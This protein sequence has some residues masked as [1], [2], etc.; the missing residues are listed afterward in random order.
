MSNNSTLVELNTH[1]FA[2]LDRLGSESLKGDALK[3]EIERGKTIATVG[4]TVID[5]ASL[6]LEAHKL[7]REYGKSKAAPGMLGLDS[8]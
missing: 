6:V 5:N 1:L 2:Q 3:E 4:R 7:E 8:K